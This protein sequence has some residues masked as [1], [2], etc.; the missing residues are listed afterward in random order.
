MSNG[1]NNMG[2]MSYS[3]IVFEGHEK[4]PVKML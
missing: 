1:M 2:G 3:N 4:N